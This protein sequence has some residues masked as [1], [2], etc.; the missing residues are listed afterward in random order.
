M[1]I[2]GLFK[3]KPEPLVI[4]DALGTF[5]LEHPQKDSFYEGE[6][7]W[8][9]GE[10]MV[11]LEIDGGGSMTADA[12][13]RHL[14]SIAAESAV[15]DKRIREYAAG[16]MAGSDGNIEIWED[17]GSGG[18]SSLTKEAF[19]RRI[20]IGF[21]RIQADGTIFFYY[22][23]DGMFTDHGLGVYADVSGDISSSEICG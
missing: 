16:D 9:G 20:S 22:D 6:I 8:P 21:I 12:A 10:A 5:T 17:D 15:W 19:I 13:R 3:G 1:S 14:H 18:G 7:Q 2:W 11:D 4:Y 23:L